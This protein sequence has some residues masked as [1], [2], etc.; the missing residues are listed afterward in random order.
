[1]KTALVTGGSG[2]IGKEI[3]LSLLKNNYNVIVTGRNLEKLADSF[4]NFSEYVQTGRLSYVE[5]DVM[6]VDTYKNKIHPII[7][8]IGN[9]DLLVNNVGG[10]KLG[11]T[12]EKT[13]LEQWNEMIGLNLTSAY[14]MSQVVLE[15]M[16]SGG[17]IINFSSILASRPANG[18]GPYCIA[19]AGIEMMTKTMALE[20]APRNI[21]VL[22]IAPATI[23]TNFHTGAGMTQVAAD[24]YYEDSASTHPIGRIGQPS[25]ISE[26]VVFLGDNTKAG[27]MTGSVISVDGGRL[28]TSAV[29]K[30]N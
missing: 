27:F 11:E 17:C 23:Q 7:N 6:Q 9:I 26:L 15:K 12:L 10:G 13:T 16:N 24:K 8:N 18:L 20:L 28:L 25:D 5:L 21:R 3:V 14:F 29:A 4:D 22:C 19:K 1:M 30:L 2:G